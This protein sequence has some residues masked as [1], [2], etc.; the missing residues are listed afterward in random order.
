VEGINPEDINA[1][2]CKHSFFMGDQT[3]YC[4]SDCQGHDE[5]GN[6]DYSPQ[7]KLDESSSSNANSSDSGHSNELITNI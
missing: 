2:I 7:G 1:E 5:L 4:V 6:N 3:A